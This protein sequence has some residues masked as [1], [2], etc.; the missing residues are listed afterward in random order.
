MVLWHRETPK[1]VKLEGGKFA[2]Y[3][4]AYIKDEEFNTFLMSYERDLAKAVYD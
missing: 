4:R 2:I 3:F 1:I